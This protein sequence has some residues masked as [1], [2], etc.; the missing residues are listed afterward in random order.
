MDEKIKDKIKQNYLFMA[1]TIKEI[2]SENF[3]AETVKEKLNRSL[4]HFNS[5]LGLLIS[6]IEKAQK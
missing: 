1:D 4:M 3:N 5:I 6:E 2:R